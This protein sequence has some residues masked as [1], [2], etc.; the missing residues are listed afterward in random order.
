MMGLLTAMQT[1]ASAFAVGIASLDQ[2]LAL[3]HSP[4]LV[5]IHELEERS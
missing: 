5:L 4:P 2:L 3:S 1:V